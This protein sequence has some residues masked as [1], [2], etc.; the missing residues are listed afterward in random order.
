MSTDI[1]AGEGNISEAT[2]EARAK[3]QALLSV[4]EVVLSEELAELLTLRELK[5]NKLPKPVIPVVLPFLTLKE[6]LGFDTAMSERGAED[7]RDHLIKAYKGLRSPGFE[8]WS[9]KGTK[10]GGFVGV[11][12]ARD[13][14]IDLQN[15]KLEYEGLR[16]DDALGRLVVDENKD[17]ATFYAL[18]SEARDAKVDGP[19]GSSSTLI[20]ALMRGYLE[21]AKCLIDR[22][23]DVN[24][25]ND[26]GETPLYQ[27]SMN[28]HLEVVRALL[29][30]KAAMNLSLIHI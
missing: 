13:R 5:W 2:A 23:A 8:E 16:G 9:F 22:G 12:W 15:L 25:A 10:E 6:T 17:M 20:E 30:A 4:E 29:D 28:G 19:Y 18:R 1:V 21:V 27:A 26:V 11:R 7:E 24:K 3:L 14:D